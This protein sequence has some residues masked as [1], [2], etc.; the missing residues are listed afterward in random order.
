MVRAK[1]AVALVAT[2]CSL[3]AQAALIRDKSGIVDF[4]DVAVE[5]VPLPSFAA[6][7]DSRN[8]KRQA[9]GGFLD[10]TP[11]SAITGNCVEATTF[12][13]NNL[14]QLEVDGSVISVNP[15]TPFIP[16]RPISP[17]GSITVTFS[18]TNG[19]LTWSNPTFFGGQAGFCQDTTGQV[20]ATFF[21]PAVAY[22]VNCQPVTLGPVIAET[23]PGGNGI[24]SSLPSTTPA[25]TG[26]IVSTVVTTIIGTG[27]DGSVFTTVSTLV[28][29]IP[30]PFTTA[31]TVVAPPTTSA[32]VNGTLT[33]RPGLY[34]EPGF[35]TPAGLYCSV[36]TESWIFGDTTLLPA[37]PTSV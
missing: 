18:L 3:V 36:V 14:G 7:F 21:D 9:T 23:C 25:P 15:G 2:S 22:P 5:D 17:A 27:S 10:T 8:R 4:V 34:P 24:P 26:P 33:L 35:A 11:G 19:V 20:Y 12:S 1:Q 29:S 32:V 13:L 6:G 37:Q 28:T 16:L 30:G 31:P